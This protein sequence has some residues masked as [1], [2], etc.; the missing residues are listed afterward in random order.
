MALQNS[1]AFQAVESGFTNCVGKKET[2]TAD[3]PLSILDANPNR[4]YVCLVLTS[5]GSVTLLFGGIASGLIGEG[6]VLTGKGSNYEITKNNLYKGEI[7][8]ISA[9]T[10]ELAIMECEKS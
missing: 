7:S 1:G 8:A 9:A 5:E 4:E 2:L 6:I 10:A 3:T